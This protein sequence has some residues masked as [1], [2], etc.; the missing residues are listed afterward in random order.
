[1]FPCTYLLIIV[2]IVLGFGGNHVKFYASPVGAA[3]MMS[4]I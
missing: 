1:M 3:G 4:Q 2:S